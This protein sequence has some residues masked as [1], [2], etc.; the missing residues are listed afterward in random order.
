MRQIKRIFVHCTASYQSTYTDAKLV[1]EFKNKGWKNPGYHYVIRPDGTIFHMLDDAE[2]ANGVSGFNTTGIHVAYVGGIS[3]EYPKGV[4]NRTPEQK[5]TMYDLLKSL[6]TKYPKALILGHRDISPDVNGNGQI[7][8]WE[9]I[10]ACP[11]FNAMKEYAD[12]NKM[13]NDH[14][15]YN[16][17]NYK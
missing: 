11:C 16:Y 13:F 12:L 8:T 4:D 5:S 17:C 9:Y 6:K 1:Q 10:K 2:I 14:V 7:D 15:S 3:K